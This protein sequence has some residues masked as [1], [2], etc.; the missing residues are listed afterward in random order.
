MV[1]EQGSTKVYRGGVFI[2]A[3]MRV[4]AERSGDA[5]ARTPKEIFEIAE[6]IRPGNREAAIAGFEELGEMAG[7]ALASAITLIDGLIVIGGGL[8]S[9]DTSCQSC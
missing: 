1:L 2:R 9:A 7:G 5:G 8:S 6:G 3:V 4:Y